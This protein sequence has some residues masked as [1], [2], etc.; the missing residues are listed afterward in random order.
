MKRVLCTL[1]ALLLMA[2]LAACGSKE[3][4]R[5]SA[6]DEPT[7]P[8][9]DSSNDAQAPDNSADAPAEPAGPAPTP[10]AE[11][12]YVMVYQGCTLPMNADFAPLLAYLGE[13]ANYFEAES[14]A[15]EGM[16]KTYTY[17]AVGVIRYRIPPTPFP[18]RRGSPSVPPRRRW[19]PP[20]ATGMTP[21]ASSTAMKTGT[22]SFP[23]FSRTARPSPWNTPRLTICWADTNHQLKYIILPGSRFKILIGDSYKK[24][25]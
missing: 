11:S 23:F 7:P 14:C 16:D 19:W 4:G 10:K 8:A 13:P 9:S 3:D 1:L 15:F 20:M 24:F 17:D 5:Q 22:A 18:R 2:S 12:K 21:L 25:L 6:A